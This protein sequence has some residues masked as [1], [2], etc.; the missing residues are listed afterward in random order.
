M[1]CFRR[2]D[3]DRAHACDL[4]VCLIS[5]TPSF[6]F[7]CQRTGTTCTVSVEAVTGLQLVTR[8]SRLRDGDRAPARDPSVGSVWFSMPV[9]LSMPAE[10]TP[11]L[12]PPP[13]AA[14][15][16]YLER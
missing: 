3:R 9:W 12:F 1:I 2:Y 4:S 8:P 13:V 15:V 10:R 16:D 6:G 5:R 14:A 7:P 11:G